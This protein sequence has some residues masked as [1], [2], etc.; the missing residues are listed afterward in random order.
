MSLFGGHTDNDDCLH[1]AM[2]SGNESERIE[3]LTQKMQTIDAN[4]TVINEW[5]SDIITTQ[6][7]FSTQDPIMTKM[8]MNEFI[9]AW[10]LPL[11]FRVIDRYVSEE[12]LVEANNQH[13][14]YATVD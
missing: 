4:P 9:S 12:S 2:K 13:L 14:L 5:L 6:K 7:Q 8:M 10:L 1:C 3:K 11:L